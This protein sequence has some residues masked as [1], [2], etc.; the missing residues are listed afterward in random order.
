MRLLKLLK[1]EWSSIN[2]CTRCSLIHLWQGRC[3]NNCFAPLKT[4]RMFPNLKT[5]H[6]HLFVSDV[7][8]RSLGSLVGRAAGYGLDDL[9]IG[10]PVPV[11]T[12]MFTSPYYPDRFWGPPNLLSKGYRGLFPQGWSCS[13]L[14]L[15]THLQLMPRSRK[16]GS[17]HPFPIRL[18]GAVLSYWRTETDNLTFTRRTSSLLLHILQFQL[19]THCSATLWPLHLAHPAV[20][21][22]NP[23]HCYTVTPSPC[24]SC[25]FSWKP[26]AVL[27]CDPLHSCTFCSF[28]WKPTAVLH[29]DSLH[30]CT[31]CSF[32]WKPTAVVMMQASA[33][34]WTLFVYLLFILMILSNYQIV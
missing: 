19:E 1:L 31:F 12:R 23:L 18:L 34:Y 6:K 20:S 13:C 32:S 9:G 29:C 28:S 8:Y 30:S 14:K 26:T 3:D 16:R 17:M 2:Y 5:V 10:V 11:W 4:S 33:F 25:S 7:L 21:G 27:H 24:T 22:G 15:T